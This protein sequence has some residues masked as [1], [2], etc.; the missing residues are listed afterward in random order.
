MV[1]YKVG[2]GCRNVTALV[3][4]PVQ[5]G[6]VRGGRLPALARGRHGCLPREGRGIVPGN[7]FTYT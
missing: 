7:L 2:V 3:H 5:P 1:E 6:G 4:V